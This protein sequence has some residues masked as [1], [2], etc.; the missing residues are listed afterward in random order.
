MRRRHLIIKELR[1]AKHRR[2]VELEGTCSRVEYVCVIHVGEN[3]ATLQS[4]GTQ[5]SSCKIVVNE[6]WMI[7]V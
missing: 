3:I 6:L 2:V 5:I 1:V 7:V 4:R